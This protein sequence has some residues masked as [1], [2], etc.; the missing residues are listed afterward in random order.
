MYKARSPVTTNGANIGTF[1]Q[2]QM[3]VLFERKTSIR[4]RIETNQVCFLY[5]TVVV[6]DCKSRM[7]IVIIFRGI[8]CFI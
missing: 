3:F 4:V 8:Y 1:L 6:S 7:C 5:M 2:S